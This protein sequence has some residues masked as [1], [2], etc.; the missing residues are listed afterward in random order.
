MPDPDGWTVLSALKEDPELRHVPVVIVSITDE[1]HRAFAVGATDWLTKPVDRA[2]LVLT[3]DRLS[4][5]ADGPVLVVEDDPDT[6]RILAQTLASRELPVLLAAD[7]GEALA[8]LSSVRPRAVL[9]D[10][11]MPEVDGFEVARRMRETP[12]WADIPIVV[13]T[14]AT[15]SAD[16]RERLAH[17]VGVFAKGSDL[18]AVVEQVRRVVPLRTPVTPTRA[19]G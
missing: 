19:V 7:G 3:V 13:L 17:C 2:R 1:D 6:R 4:R 18:T 8:H 10:L 12:A 9:L 5:G 15:L 16:D 11:M 14:A